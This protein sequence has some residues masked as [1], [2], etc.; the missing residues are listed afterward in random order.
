MEGDFNAE[1]LIKHFD[2]LR[3]GPK[4]CQ[5][6]PAIYEVFKGWATCLKCQQKFGD[7]E[8]D[9]KPEHTDIRLQWRV[10]N[11]LSQSDKMSL[12][13]LDPSGA[14]IM[15]PGSAIERRKPGGTTCATCWSTERRYHKHGDG[16]EEGE[17]DDSEFAANR[18]MHARGED[19]LKK[20]PD[21]SGGRG[22]PNAPAA[23]VGGYG[24]ICFLVC[25][26]LMVQVE[27]LFGCMM[28]ALLDFCMPASAELSK[29]ALGVL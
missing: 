2:A 29:Y 15:I 7:F 5:R 10:F 13:Q 25:G 11:A 20:D 27:I 19:K 21:V 28:W 17:P 6:D 3:C 24:S 9:V 26:C 14:S 8:K 1:L 18:M 22:N 12:R 4:Q 16:E 23:A